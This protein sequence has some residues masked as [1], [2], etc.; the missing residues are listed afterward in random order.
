[1]SGRIFVVGHASRLPILERHRKDLVDGVELEAFLARL[2]FRNRD[3]GGP[4][5]ATGCLDR[6]P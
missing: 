4:K 5:D 1:M 2:A 3:D 6:M